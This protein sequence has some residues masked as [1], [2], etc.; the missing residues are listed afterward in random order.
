MLSRNVLLVCA[1]APQSWCH[2]VLGGGA[3][4]SGVL[5]YHVH[6]LNDRC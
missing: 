5:E 3:L 1:G 4:S 2:F 6:A